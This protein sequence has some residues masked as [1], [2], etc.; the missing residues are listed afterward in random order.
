ML[1]DKINSYIK[2]TYKNFFSLCKKTYNLKAS[3]LYDA[4][5]YYNLTYTNSH[6]SC[7]RSFKTFKV[8]NYIKF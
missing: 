6:L 4:R 3:K 5:K 2:I 7:F 8:N 1:V